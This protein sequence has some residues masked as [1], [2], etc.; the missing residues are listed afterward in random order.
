MEHSLTPLPTFAHTPAFLAP[1]PSPEPQT[2][3]AFTRPVSVFLL[4]SK[5]HEGRDCAVLLTSVSL[6]FSTEPGT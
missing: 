5:S 3:T 1:T 2:Y 4:E 6:E